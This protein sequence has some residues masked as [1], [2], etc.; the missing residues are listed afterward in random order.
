MLLENK[1]VII[2]GGSRGIGRRVS[3]AR[4]GADVVVNYCSDHSPGPG[5]MGPAEEVIEAIRVMGRKAIGVEADVADPE[6]CTYA[7]A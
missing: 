3:L 6:N 4:H 7:A 1:V 2:T 5:Q